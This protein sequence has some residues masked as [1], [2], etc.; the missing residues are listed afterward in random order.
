VVEPAWND[1]GTLLAT[2][3]LWREPA[4]DRWRTGDVTYPPG[5]DPD[6][7][8]WLFE[9]VVDGTPEGYVAFAEEY[10]ETDVD[11]DAVRAV[12]AREPLTDELVRRLN[13]HATL[14]ALAEDLAGIGYPRGA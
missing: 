11:L 8:D 5:G 9:V 13:P 7:A 10:F 12:L 3:C 14:D 2:A 6:G 4:D 1:A